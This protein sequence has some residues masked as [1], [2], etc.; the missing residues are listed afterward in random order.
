[1]NQYLF[2]IE[3]ISRMYFE[4]G[5]LVLETHVIGVKSA[6]IDKDYIRRD[7]LVAKLDEYAEKT[8]KRLDHYVRS[9]LHGC[10][11]DEQTALAEIQTLKRLVTGD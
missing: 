7:E 4:E 8:Q 1:M 9:A 3:D 6:E 10:A 5:M 2:P 11:H